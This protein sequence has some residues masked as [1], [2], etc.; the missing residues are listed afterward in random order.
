MS[1]LKDI[2]KNGW[3]PKS[4]DMGDLKDKWKVDI[5]ALNQKGWMGKGKSKDTNEQRASRPLQ[6]LTD[7]TTFGPPPRKIQI[8]GDDKTSPDL[9]KNGG[10][11]STDSSSGNDNAEERNIKSNPPPIPYRASN[12]ELRPPPSSLPK[13][14]EIPAFKHT[15]SSTPASA[16][17]T[18]PPRLPPRDKSIST[19]Q[20]PSI[21]ENKLQKRVPR[22][23]FSNILEARDGTKNEFDSTVKP[24]FS[25][26]NGTTFAQK[27]AAIKTIS[28]FSRDPSSVSISDIKEAA[29]TTNNFRERH[30]DQ[31]NHNGISEKIGQ[32]QAPSKAVNQLHGDI[33][34]ED[35][36]KKIVNKKR[37]PPPPPPKLIKNNNLI[38]PSIDLKKKTPPP[39]V[40]ETK[41]KWTILSERT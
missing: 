15:E 9:R 6:S 32:L 37:P 40:I 19:Q 12:Q 26:K 38:D 39:I 20:T 10:C 16:K 7:P 36:H 22:E 30:N 27:K 21:L 29:Y 17:S 11:Y 13:Y 33:K 18:L 31:V 28:S 3:H 35:S 1:T 2:A 14:S 23:G 4:K 41:P 34:S 5:K 25:T 8:H 24:P